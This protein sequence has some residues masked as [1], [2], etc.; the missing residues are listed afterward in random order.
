MS[1]AQR[2]TEALGGH[3][4][5]SYGLALCPAH[6]NTQT[7]ALS[8]RHGEDGKLLAHCFVGCQ[9]RDVMA[10]LRGAGL[11]PAGGDRDTSGAW[12]RPGQARPGGADRIEAARRA[13]VADRV[14]QEARPLPGTPG[15]TYLRGRGI[16]CP[17]P[18]TLRYVRNCSHPSGQRLPAM[19]ARID[20]TESFAVH[21]TYLALG[22]AGKAEATPAKAMLGVT[23]GGAV[24]LSMPRDA[25]CHDT[26]GEAVPLVVT[27]GIEN[28]LSLRCGLMDGPAEVWAAL[29][30]SGLKSLT[31]PR[32]PGHLVIAGDNDP[33]G[34]AAVTALSHRATGLGWRVSHL[35]PPEGQDWNEVLQGLGVRS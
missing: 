5:G 15:E 28:G 22:G 8:L 35:T 14:W 26:A 11:D 20:G 16:T 32:V 10:A 3:W 25:T 9:F 30:T 18:A 6:E 1:E 24:R 12:Q 31:L 23:R 17:L 34:R 27:E 33:A 21:R 29:S 7:P 2:L 19:V 4:Y 13:R